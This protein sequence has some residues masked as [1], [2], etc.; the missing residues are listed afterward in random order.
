MAVNGQMDTREGTPDRKKEVLASLEDHHGIVTDACGKVG[1]ARSTFYEWLKN[2]PEFKA[3]VDEIQEVA[4]D[5]VESKLFERIK[6]VEVYKGEDK[7]T[8]EMITYTLPPDVPA[9][10]LYLKTRGKKRGYVERQEITGAD[11]NNLNFNVTLD[12]GGNT[13]HT[14]EPIPGS[15]GK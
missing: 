11:G 12:L 3:A 10:S 2:D 15:E 9:I 7:D 14:I 4:I 8:G 13:K 1:L 5:F 6:G